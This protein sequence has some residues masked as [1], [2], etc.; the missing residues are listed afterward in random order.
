G[1]AII[2]AIDSF[3]SAADFAL[4][5]T[6]AL[7]SLIF[8]AVVLFIY[9]W[10]STYNGQTARNSALLLLTGDMAVLFWTLI[11]VIGIVVPL[12]I[13]FIAGPGSTV[14]LIISAVLFLA[15]NLIMRYS[16]IKAGRYTAL[17]QSD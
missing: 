17:P 1:A 16:L 12:A 11:V 8:Y 3:T 2:L 6:V 13:D 7:A 15:G 9:L 5:L 10:V 14:L 4:V